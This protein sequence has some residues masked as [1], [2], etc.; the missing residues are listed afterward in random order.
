MSR[1]FA[2]WLLQRNFEKIENITS[3]R[4]YREVKVINK[5]RN[6]TRKREGKDVR[7]ERKQGKES[8]RISSFAAKG[9][10]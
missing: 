7:R 4:G 1:S 8:K 9:S 5:V 3:L 6:V 2:K 10:M